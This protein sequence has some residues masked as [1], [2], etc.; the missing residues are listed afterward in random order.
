SHCH[1]DTMA[2]RDH[3]AFPNRWNAVWRTGRRNAQCELPAFAPPPPARG[4]FAGE[5]LT[6]W[7]SGPVCSIQ[8][9][10]RNR[11]LAKR[12]AGPP[13]LP[14]VVPVIA[15]LPNSSPAVEDG[16]VRPVRK[17]TLRNP[18]SPV[19]AMPG[20]VAMNQAAKSRHQVSMGTL[21]ACARDHNEL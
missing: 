18:D 21:V 9:V 2:A 14:P 7:Q 12:I 3:P 10:R 17:L 16:G 20:N 5:P 4:S 13:R 19:A 15:A 6:C 11:L 1:P 8:T